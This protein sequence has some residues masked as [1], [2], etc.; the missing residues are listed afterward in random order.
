MTWIR[1]SKNTVFFCMLIT[2]SV[3]GSTSWA[4]QVLD[5]GRVIED[6]VDNVLSVDV[7]Q[8]IEQL[9]EERQIIPSLKYDFKTYSAA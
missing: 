2:I 6:Q 1:T 7:E 3:I 5:E 4:D 9:G 8:N